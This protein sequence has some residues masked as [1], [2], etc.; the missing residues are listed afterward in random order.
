M[1]DYQKILKQNMIRVLKDI[2]NYISLNGYSDEN[3]LYITFS[4][5]NNNTKI[6]IWLK[7]KYPEE[8]TIIIQYEYYELK[9]E[10]DYFEI[11][12]SFNNIKTKLKINYNSVISFADPYSKFG[13]ILKNKKIQTNLK[14]KT[15]EKKLNKNN[16]LDLSKFRKS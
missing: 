12:L 5:K 1:I 2:L 4:T 7:K 6:P 13:L 10:E 16:V 11:T 14:N 15:D 8:M 3:H 9:V